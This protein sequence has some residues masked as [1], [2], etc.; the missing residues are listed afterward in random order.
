MRHLTKIKLINWHFFANETIP[1]DGDTLITGDNGAGKSTLIDA[2]QV[3]IIANLKK[4]RFNSSAMEDRTTRDIR[5][6]LRGKTGVEGK[7]NYLRNEDFSSY[8]V[9]EITRTTTGTPYL[10]GVV[11][12]YFHTTGEEEHV[13]F[14]I[15]EE[16]LHDDLFFKG[17][18]E[19]RN[20]GEFFNYLK[21]RDVKFQQY[22]NDLN[23]Y[24]YD[25][26]QLFGGAK[27]SFF[28]LFTK[29]ISF[30]PITELRSFVYDYILEEHP[31]DV[32]NMQEYFEKFRQVEQMIDDTKNEIAALEKLEDSYSDIEKLYETLKIND[33]MVARGAYEVQLSNIGEMKQEKNR[34]LDC[35]EEIQKQIIEANS[36][37]ERI[38]E[39][40]T[41]LET[42]MRE[43]EAKQKEEELNRHLQM[44]REKL[45]EL[46][47]L[48]KNLV[49]RF[50]AEAEELE[51][52]YDILSALN[53]PVEITG[54]LLE[55]KEAW[56]QSVD[57]GRAVLPQDNTVYAGAWAKAMHWLF[58]QKDLWQKE[59]DDLSREEIR[60]KKMIDDLEN[61][62]VLGTE[63]PT[64]KLKGVLEEN[65]TDPEGEKLPV[66][67]L[68]EAIDIGNERWRNAIEGYL[69]TQKFDLLVPPAYFNEALSLYENHR[70]TLHIERVGLVNTGKLMQEKRG[71]DQNSLAEEITASVDYVAAYVN[72]LLGS[73]IKCDSEREL[74]NY[75]RSI[76]DSCMLYQNHTARQIPSSRYET[77]YIG[78]EA[79]RTQLLRTRHLLEE[80]SRQRSKIGKNLNVSAPT[81]SFST[82][83]RDRYNHW[84]EEAGKLLEKNDLSAALEKTQ[85]ELLS[86]DFSEYENFERDYHKNKL[87]MDRLDEQLQDLNKSL[88]G[89]E[90]KIQNIN[91]QLENLAEQEQNS[92][93]LLIRLEEQLDKEILEQCRLKWKKEVQERNPEV[94]YHNYSRNRDGINTR[95]NN[96]RNK[97]IKMRTEYVYSYNFPGDPE[98]Q[99]NCAFN[100]R[101]RTLIDSH[102]RDYEKQAREA[103]EKA[104]H[105]FQEH[106][107]ARLGEYIKLAR[108]EIKEL[109]RALQGMRFG[110]EEYRFSLVAK[111]ETKHYYDM[112]MDSGV[113]EGSIFRPTFYEKYGDAINDLF[114]EI[115][116]RDSELK[117]TMYALTDYRTYLDF[118]ITITD[119]MGYKSNFSKV[120]RDKS[121]GETQVPFYVA[122]LASFYQA[123]QLYRKSD[124]LRLVVFDEAFNRM[125]AD[126]IEEAIRFMQK[127]GFQ[128]MIV[129]P[130][131]RIQLI[132]PYMNTNLVVMKDNFTSFIEKATRKELIESGQKTE[133]RKVKEG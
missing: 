31:L 23:R 33:Y 78:K 3:V 13:F 70:Y 92:Q 39:T 116:N 114:N 50:I 81:D 1:V 8:I 79:I 58:L 109:N 133:M 76:T 52:L 53:A 126:R 15:D 119:Q 45:D 73:V 84:S 7:S 96:Q 124:T 20:R 38:K 16:H 129:A 37:K 111:A 43:N 102:L 98:S 30:S 26:R 22:R 28:S 41:G 130:T 12:D 9:L 118:D 44:L 71:P 32:E 54:V 4:V 128:A 110:S 120:A 127:L 10:I 68:C 101:Y 121:G 29:G 67:I 56:Q 6:Y 55:A 57:S 46:M 61:N 11:F 62:R 42:L 48:E 112:V 100:Q 59:K 35:K 95:I 123:Y 93:Q 113:Y 97:L 72:H 17:P 132:V 80:L 107:I 85:K 5:S 65:L 82:D 88:G 94:L 40:L 60:L 106:F 66:H 64:M 74:S 24:I 2:I 125:D 87:E 21:A 91:V 49:H 19:L 90:S 27:E 25:L 99:D 89:L 75:R 103:R 47:C 131:G 51:H 18:Q 34:F 105:S 83:K 86:L 122:I 77:P 69:H 14:R 104:E 108:E 115:A 117:E 63:S 36:N